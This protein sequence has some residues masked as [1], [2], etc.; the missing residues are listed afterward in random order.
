MP[1]NDIK[2]I[3]NKIFELF[4]IVHS[5]CVENSIRYYFLGGSMLGAVRHNGFIPWD[6]DIDIGM[7]RADYEKFLV[8]FNDLYSESLDIRVYNYMSDSSCSFDFTKLLHRLTINDVE[9]DVFVDIFPLDGCPFSSK[10]G[11]KLFYCNFNLMRLAKNTHFMDENKGNVIRKY[12][13][14]LLKLRSLDKWESL[15]N[16][17]LKRNSFDT[18][19]FAGNYS[20]HWGSK[21]IMQKSVYGEPRLIYFVDNYYFGVSEPDIYLTNLYGNYMKLPDEKDRLSH[22]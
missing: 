18:C 16:N 21:E 5:F 2:I 12:I 11:I 9:Q 14:K 8:L 3:Q 4:K 20:G 1:D 22:F 7:P 17:Y 10:F 13:I 6:D 15:L 19:K